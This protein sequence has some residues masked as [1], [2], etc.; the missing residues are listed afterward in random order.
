MFSLPKKPKGPESELKFDSRKSPDGAFDWIFIN[1]KVTDLRLPLSIIDGEKAIT[2]KI[3][4]TCPAVLEKNVKGVLTFLSEK[5]VNKLLKRGKTNNQSVDS[6]YLYVSSAGCTNEKSS[7]SIL[8]LN[9]L[10]DISNLVTIKI[11]DILALSKSL[12]NKGIIFDANSLAHID[13]INEKALQTLNL[14][15]LQTYSDYSLVNVETKI[16]KEVENSKNN[17]VSIEEIQSTKFLSLKKAIV[18]KSN[19]EKETIL[20]GHRPNIHLDNKDFHGPQATNTLPFLKDKD[21]NFYLVTTKENRPPLDGENLVASPAGLCDLEDMDATVT[22]IREFHEETDIE[23]GQI[24]KDLVPYFL[25]YFSSTT[26]SV[27]EVFAGVALIGEVDNLTKDELEKGIIIPKN[28]DGGVTVSVILIKIEK[29]DSIEDIILKLSQF[30]AIDA[31]IATMLNVFYTGLKAE[32]NLPNVEL[33]S[34]LE[35]I[36]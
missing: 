1:T 31:H 19:G 22:A 14:T 10:P 27:S 7:A 15:N 9:F 23:K 34:L 29:N 36:S 8:I 13:S 32:K 24:C 2:F 20:Y 25:G 17:D 12:S 6:G 26:K 33:V 30:G 21:G 28:S 18:T 3:D 11:S 16:L 35:Q 5:E 4:T